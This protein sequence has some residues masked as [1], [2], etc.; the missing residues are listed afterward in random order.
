MCNIASPSTLPGSLLVLSNKLTELIPSALVCALVLPFALGLIPIVRFDSEQIFV[1]VHPTHLVVVGEYDYRNILPLPVGQALA[2]PF[3]TDDTHSLP[4][5]CVV[6]DLSSRKPLVS[7][8]LPAS[9]GFMVPFFPFEKKTIRVTYSQRCEF[10]NGKYI[11]L[12]TRP[13]GNPLKHGKYTIIEC[14]T[15]IVGSNYAL[16]SNDCGFLSFERSDFMPDRDWS[17]SWTK[18]RQCKTMRMTQIGK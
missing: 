13:W 16:S 4:E 12:T 14:D 5:V 10:P 9:R 18:A 1:Y 8:D 7:Y 6:E 2:C 17:F 3:S 11:L 15:K